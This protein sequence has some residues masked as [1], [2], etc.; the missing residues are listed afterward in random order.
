MVD[1]PLMAWITNYLTGRPQHARLQNN[2]N[3]SDKTVNSTGAPQGMALSCT[4]S[5]PQTSDTA[6]SP[7]TCTFTFYMKSFSR[8]FCPKRR[9]RER[10]VKLR[11]I[12]PGVTINT[13]LHKKYKLPFTKLRYVATYAMCLYGEDMCR[14]V[15]AV[16]AS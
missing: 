9:T 4:R 15:T 7:A 16:S 8:R 2:N 11:A 3:V 6:H 1:A 12:E 10:I 14:N 13:T 5:T